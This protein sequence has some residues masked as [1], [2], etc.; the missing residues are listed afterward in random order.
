MTFEL[1]EN[2]VA[3]R[4]ALLASG[5]T[6][7]VRLFNGFI[8]GLPS[9]A[10]DLY[11]GTA[12][13]HDY[14][15]GGDEGLVRG[16]LEVVQSAYPQVRSALW[17]VRQDPLEARRNGVLLLGERTDLTRRVREHGVRYAVELDLNRD[18]SLY[19]DTRELR[20]WAQ[21]SLS[22]QRVLNT[23]AYTG[24]LGVAARA[25]GAH[26]VQTD[27]NRRFLNLAK[28]SYA[29]NG[30][31]VRRQDFRTGDFFDVAGQ[32]K[33]EQALFDCVFVDP[34]FFSV[35]RAGRV[36]LEADVRRLVN[37]VRP[38]VAHDGRLVLVDNALFLPGA[39]LMQTLEALCA[40]GYLA[41][42]RLVPVPE[43][44][45]GYPQTR[46]GEPP[47]DPSPFNHSTKIVVLSVRRR[48]E[49]R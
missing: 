43:D 35:T 5:D 48:D 12:V 21:Q 20:R 25:A 8:E 26:V 17:K 18:A 19:L 44:A 33:R 9:L 16:A 47:A 2:A 7:A 42:E 32:L 41:V 30:W 15:D 14:S 39:A 38:L 10:I 34:P 11:G 49:R 37:K 23:F 1:I 3:C 40:D 6:T 46:R 28:D 36:D 45:A 4:R 13:F 29:L 22:G 31:P 27:L 24:S